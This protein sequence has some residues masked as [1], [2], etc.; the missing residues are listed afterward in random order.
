MVTALGRGGGGWRVSA[1][2][3]TTATTATAG[4][5]PPGAASRTC[6]N[7][8]QL[9]VSY[10]K[11]FMMIEFLSIFDINIVLGKL[12]LLERICLDHY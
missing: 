10:Y 5:R 4:A 6:S 7:F 8:G 2:T 9:N 11:A 1:P 12:N 3:S